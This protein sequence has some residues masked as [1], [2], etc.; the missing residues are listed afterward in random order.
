[1]KNFYENFIKIDSYTIRLISFGLLAFVGT[2]FAVPT[3]GLI[4]TLPIYLIAVLFSVLIKI[5]I[6]QK[7]LFFGMFAFIFVT[8]D[9][10]SFHG[11]FF[12]ALCILTLLICSISF[13]LFK[14][15][16][17]L[18]IVIAVILISICALPHAYF[19]GN[20]SDGFNADKVLVKYADTHYN[21]DNMVI[22]GTYYDYKIGHYKSIV[23]DKNVPTEIYSMVVQNDKVYD[24]YVSYV[25]ETLM[26]NKMLDITNVLRD[27]FADDT[28][29]V[30][31]LEIAGYPIS[32]EISNND[33]TDYSFIMRFKILV[34]GLID[35]DKFAE[36]SKEY[37]DAIIESN[38][39]F[40]EIVFTG[41]DIRRSVLAISVTPKTFYGDFSMLIKPNIDIYTDCTLFD[42]LK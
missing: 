27:N 14:K 1:M 32:D 37:F 18:T 16:K 24:S 35:K 26:H 22:S 8:I 19:F 13:S 25:Q 9:Y 38:I 3:R 5:P 36:K 12:A 4:S 29:K 20:Y 34:P 42:Y 30:I 39:N 2:F 10:D 6:W 17:A 15:K 23:Y 41:K 33:T 11:L 21:K 31:P 28:F 40:G 7:S